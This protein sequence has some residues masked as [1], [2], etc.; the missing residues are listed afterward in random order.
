MTMQYAGLS[1]PESAVKYPRSMHRSYSGPSTSA[2]AYED[3]RLT[4]GRGCSAVGVVDMDPM[5]RIP[6]PGL[7]TDNATRLVPPD[8][9][10]TSPPPV[11]PATARCVRQQSAD[12]R[13]DGSVH[14]D[15]RS[16]DVG[17]VEQVRL[18]PL[19]WQEE[20]RDER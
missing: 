3:G 14:D 19:A 12:G 2:G 6:H 11:V 10:R 5:L 18:L 7:R 9:G 17:V 20:R 13:T 1:L 8:P 15:G 4:V 16:L